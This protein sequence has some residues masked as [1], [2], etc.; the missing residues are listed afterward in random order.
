MKRPTP[1][2]A[3]MMALV[4][5]QR[6]LVERAGVAVGHAKSALSREESHLRGLEHNLRRVMRNHEIIAEAATVPWL[7][8]KFT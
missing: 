4:A 6:H 8:E 5:A 7:K 3:Y 1:E 2:A